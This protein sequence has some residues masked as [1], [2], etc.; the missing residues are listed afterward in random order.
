M[1]P[2]DL[3]AVGAVLRLAFGKRTKFELEHR[4]RWADGQVR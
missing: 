1:R 3:P 4:I 2:D